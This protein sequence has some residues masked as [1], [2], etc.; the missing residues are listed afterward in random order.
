MGEEREEGE[1]RTEVV[2]ADEFFLPERAG[3]TWLMGWPVCR[4]YTSVLGAVNGAATGAG[5]FRSLLTRM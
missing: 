3:N 4:R 5:F 2:A 1:S